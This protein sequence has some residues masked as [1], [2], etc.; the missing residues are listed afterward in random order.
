V[1]IFPSVYERHAATLR[2]GGAVFLE[3]IVQAETQRVEL[4]VDDVIP[5]DQIW[6][7]AIRSLRVRLPAAAAD[8]PRLLRLRELLDLSPGDA[9]VALSIELEE[10][11]CAE[12]ALRAHRVEVSERLVE[13]I[14]RLFGKGA[15]ECRP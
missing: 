1:L 6:S 5:L 4:R 8:A 11:A 14:E 15:F 12:L 2:R 13:E 3:G 9:S 10:G 7:R